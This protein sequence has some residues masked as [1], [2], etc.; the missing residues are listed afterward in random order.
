MGY[1]ACCGIPGIIEY[2]TLALVKNNVLT[3]LKQKKINSNLYCYIRNPLAL[4]CCAFNYVFYMGGLL[5]MDS[6]I[7]VI[8]INILFT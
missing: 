8:Y 6:K 4:F 2:G 5:E 1:I 7:V 3:S